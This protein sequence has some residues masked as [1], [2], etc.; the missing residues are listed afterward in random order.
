MNRLLRWPVVVVVGRIEFLFSSE[1]NALHVA[2]ELPSEC[3]CV[4]VTSRLPK[5]RRMATDTHTHM[6]N[7]SQMAEVKRERN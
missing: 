5:T 3:V 1:M 7:V 6:Q 4:C 2:T